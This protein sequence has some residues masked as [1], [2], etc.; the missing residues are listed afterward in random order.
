MNKN[1]SKIALFMIMGSL[2][3]SSCKK[4]DDPDP[5]PSLNIPSVY[6]SV[7]YYENTQ[8][9]RDIYTS[10]NNFMND[11]KR[12]RAG[13]ALTESVMSGLY[14]AGSPSIEDITT[15]YYTNVVRD[16]FPIMEAASTNTFLPDSAPNGVGGVYGSGS[17]AY[18]YD[19]YGTDMD[20]VIEKGLFEAAFYNYATNLVKANITPA[21]IDK[22]LAIFGATPVLANSDRVSVGADRFVALYTARRDKN[23]GNGFYS[24]IKLAL[25]T[26]KAATLAGSNYNTQ[27]DEAIKS[28]FQNWE[29]SMAATTINYCISASKLLSLT[30][31][32]DDE[33]SRALHAIGEGIGFIYGFKTINNPYRIITDDQIDEI[34]D[35]FLFPNNGN[36]EI[37]KFVTESFTNLPKLGDN[38]GVIKKLQDIYGFSNSQIAD[39]E[40][41][42]VNEQNR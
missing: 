39:F 7:G 8:E 41:N 13:Q 36:I 20:Q 3:L 27:R 1:I 6:D 33:K 9:V 14:T 35:L 15:T 18:L 16:F 29:R 40:K 4:G 28:Y 37:Y 26:A 10:F 34:M 5:V 22:L 12:G 38:T 17:A 42:W 21:T 31:P 25:L 24:K 19:Q 30:A 11:L 23:D 32:T 2:A